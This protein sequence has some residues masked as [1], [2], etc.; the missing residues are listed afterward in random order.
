MKDSCA[1]YPNLGW[2]F[3]NFWDLKY[4][5]SCSPCFQSFHWEICCYSDGFAS[6]CELAFV[7]CSF[8]YSFLVLYT[9][10]F[11]YN[12]PWRVF[13]FSC[14]CLFG[15]LKAFY[16]WMTVSFSRCG[17]FSMVFY[18]IYFLCVWLAPLLLCPWFTGFVF[19]W[20]P[21]DLACL[22]HTFIFFPLSWDQM[23]FKA[24]PSS[25]I[26]RSIRLRLTNS[27]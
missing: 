9:Y 12:I 1:Q 19:K 23:I 13:F 22:V 6:I 10:C 5:I 25:N 27:F 14:S 4:I 20:C 21:R 3:F 15:V 2:Q 24:L 18:W 16:S 11:N 26:N 7:S 8:H 17:N